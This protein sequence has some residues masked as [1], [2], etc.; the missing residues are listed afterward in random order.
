MSFSRHCQPIQRLAYR[1]TTV[2]R[3]WKELWLWIWI[4]WRHPPRTWPT[5]RVVRPLPPSV[6]PRTRLR[7]FT[8]SNWKLMMVWSNRLKVCRRPSAAWTIPL[9]DYRTSRI[10]FWPRTVPWRAAIAHLTPKGGT[11]RLLRLQG[12]QLFL[13]V[14][15][16]FNIIKT[17]NMV[18]ISFNNKNW[19]SFQQNKNSN[20]VVH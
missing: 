9:S 17:Q 6:N 3:K 11:V 4:I 10:W 16:I 18:N 7:N 14:W 12:Q 13:T 2:L 19:K 15:T 20:F 8:A 5:I 1:P